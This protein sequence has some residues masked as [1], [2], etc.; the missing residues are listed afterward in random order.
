MRRGTVNRPKRSVFPLRIIIPLVFLIIGVAAA[1]SLIVGDSGPEPRKQ[2]VIMGPQDPLPPI[3]PD[4]YDQEQN[5]TVV[6]SSAD[7]LLNGIIVGPVGTSGTGEVR[8]DQ[9]S[10]TRVKAYKVNSDA[11]RR[12][13]NQYGKTLSNQCSGEIT[14]LTDDT[15][16]NVRSGPSTGNPVVTKVPKGSRQSVLLWAPD[17]RTQSGRWFL[18][19]DD[20]KKT[21]TGWVS[22]EYC[23]TAGVVFAN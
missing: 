12:T 18:L 20:E 15:P 14:V 2:V 11:L 4:E 23:D 6:Q 22:G 5:Y 17:S 10:D 21:V 1:Y 16:L 8:E 7:I 9:F 3:T 13:V 19:V